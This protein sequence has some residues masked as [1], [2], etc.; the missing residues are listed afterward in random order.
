MPKTKKGPLS[1]VECFYIDGNKENLEVAEIACDLNRSIVSIE[2]HI[3]K[4]VRTRK[5]SNSKV[6]AGE[7]F[8]RQSGA[9]IM[10]ENASTIADSNK[11]VINKL[12]SH[13]TTKI[14]D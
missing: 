8:I 12:P 5:K 7:Q 6:T 1:K 9:T 3:K 2:N 10:S 13:C 4:S 14:K 11:K